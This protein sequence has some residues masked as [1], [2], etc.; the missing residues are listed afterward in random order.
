MNPAEYPPGPAESRPPRFI[1]KPGV[2]R[3][4]AVQLLITLGLVFATAPIV[5]DLPN[6][7]VI[8][9]ALLTVVMLS[10]V[11]AV[12]GRRRVLLAALIL[13]IPAVTGKWLHHIRP[14]I[15]APVFFLICTVI[16]FG[17]VVGHLLRFI[18]LAPRVDLNVLSAGIAGFLMLG[19]L[20]MPA[21][22][23]IARVN[24][25]AF[26]AP[27][28]PGG[29]GSVKGF[30]AFYFSFATLC[31]VGYGDI[32]PVSKGARMLAVAEAITGLL[33]IAVLISRLV[34][35]YSSVRP[36]PEASAETRPPDS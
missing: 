22:S 16:F 29:G 26:S 2:F 4:S 21:Y 25:A 31:T 33:Y 34:S 11:L 8:E 17:F 27:N 3:F 20:W 28:E 24:P 32:T 13:V 7:N 12:G 6:G 10:G 15:D 1:L 9:A 30:T 18:V 19:L 5:E 14:G 36:A 35:M 23:A